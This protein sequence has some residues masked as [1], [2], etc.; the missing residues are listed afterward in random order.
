M[1]QYCIGVFYTITLGGL[2]IGW[3]VGERARRAAFVR[4]LLLFPPAAHIRPAPP[5]CP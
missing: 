3:L 4:L 2:G 5:L 1:E